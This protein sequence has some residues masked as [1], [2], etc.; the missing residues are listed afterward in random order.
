MTGKKRITLYLILLIILFINSNTSYSQDDLTFEKVDSVSYEL[1]KN[2]KWSE[3]IRFGNRALKDGMDSYGLRIRLGTAYYKVKNY[4]EAINNFENAL[5]VGYEDGLI[6]E[7]LYFAYM[8]T[9]RTEDKNFVFSKLPPWKKE[10]LR[11]LYN[12][13]IDNIFAEGDMGISNDVNHFDEVN[14]MV[15]VNSYGDQVISGDYLQF[16]GGISQLPFNRLNVS[17]EYSYLNLK[18]NQEIYTNNAIVQSSENIDYSQTQNRFYNSIDVLAAR[19][20]VISP[21]AHY[22]NIKDIERV[23]DSTSVLSDSIRDFHF[24]N[25]EFNKENFIL[26]LTAS[27]YLSRFKIAVNGSFSQL[28]DAHQSQFGLSFSGFPLKNNKFFAET[29]ATLHNQDNVSNLIFTQLLGITVAKNL[30]LQTYASLGRIQNFNEQNG[31]TVYNEEDFLKFKFGS[32]LIYNFSYNFIATL[33][34]DHQSRE[35]NF[36]V[37]SV[38]GSSSNPFQSDSKK[39]DYEV[40]RLSAGLKFYF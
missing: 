35:R 22:I 15:T 28:N 3:L 25:K 18:K 16:H 7:F 26:S 11:P 30:N 6:Y 14:Q 19:G 37:Y 38:D 9:G 4:F 21:A 29:N 5:D 2:Q 39:I 23:F 1:Y 24:S 31:R 40:I 32:R 17:Y 10:T 34:F 27:K 33:T 20:L 36:T 13:F 8:F 12:M